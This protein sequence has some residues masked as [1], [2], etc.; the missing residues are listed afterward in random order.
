MGV[1]QVI[2]FLSIRAAPNL[3]FM[4]SRELLIV[5]FEHHA[6][7]LNEGFFASVV[8]IVLSNNAWVMLVA[9]VFQIVFVV[10]SGL[11]RKTINRLEALKETEAGQ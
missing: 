10:L 5:Q 1:G 7:R 4:T 3:V 8:I 11:C 6:T 2:G 9:L